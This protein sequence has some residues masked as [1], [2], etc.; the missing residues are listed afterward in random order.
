M[1]DNLTGKAI[2]IMDLDTVMPGLL[3]YDFGDAI[4]FG[5]NTAAEDE[6]DLSRVSLDLRLY[7]AYVKGF[8]TGC[9]EAMTEQERKLLP[10][11]ALVMTYECGLRFLTDY[12]EGDIYFKT[13]H[14]THNL[15]RCRT[16][17][18]LLADMIN[19]LPEMRT[20]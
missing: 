8:T 17:F 15:D 13:D 18:A 11:S 4:R 6:T 5:A 20:F 19:K 3:A 16:Q 12:L 14:P 9:G 1:F 2:C 10:E 7:E